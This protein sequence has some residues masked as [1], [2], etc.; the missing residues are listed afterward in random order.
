MYFTKLFS[1]RSYKAPNILNKGFPR[2][3]PSPRNGESSGNGEYPGNGESPGNGL[4][5]PRGIMNP[6]GIPVD[7]KSYLEF[8]AVNSNQRNFSL[9]SEYNATS[10]KNS[11]TTLLCT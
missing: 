3:L 9:S 2:I 4:G 5:N 11:L 6:W 10:H 8:L 1:K 7:F